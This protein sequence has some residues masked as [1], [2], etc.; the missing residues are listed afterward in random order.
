[1]LICLYIKKNDNF[2]TKYKN[3]LVLKKISKLYDKNLNF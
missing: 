1:M 2:N 3:K